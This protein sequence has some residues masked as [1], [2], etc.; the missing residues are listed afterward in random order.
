MPPRVIAI[1]DVHGCATALRKLIEIVRPEPRDTLVVLG[2]C[3]DRGPE[4]R[5]VVDDLLALREK[6]R[7]IPILGNHEEMMLN[8]LDGRPQPDDWLQCGG[9]ATVE[10]YR[11]ADGKLVPVPA[12]HVDYIRTWG[13]CYQTDTHFF[14][15]ASYE[16]DRPL[17][18]QHWQTMRWHSLRDGIPEAHASG[19]TA[20]VGHT[21][22]KDGEIMDLGYLFCIDT[23]CW[24]G[25]WL[26]ALDTTTG[27]SWQVD[28]DG[29]VRK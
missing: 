15:H 24:G 16:P 13:D 28:R 11:G 3:V 9:A 10:S 1:G 4:S 22:Q 25:G 18:K 19:K 26:T 14:V 17:P 29:R 2:D 5:Q 23:Y 12:E 7:L 21:S 8:F 6:C 27:Q 20:V